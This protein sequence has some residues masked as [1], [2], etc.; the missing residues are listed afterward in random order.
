MFY[1]ALE[2]SLH[3]YLKAKLNIETSEMSK[4]RI[5]QLLQERDVEQGTVTQFG[6]LLKS[7]EFAR[8]T[9]TSNVTIQQDYD[10]AVETISAIDKQI[11]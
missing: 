1:E 9:P 10:K 4:E 3:N 7:C 2:R 11:Q 8:Y 5:A 6:S